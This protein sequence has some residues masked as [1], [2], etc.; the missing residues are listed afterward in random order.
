M[1]YRVATF[2]PSLPRLR[3]WRAVGVAELVAAV[4]ALAVAAGLAPHLWKHGP[5]TMRAAAVA[6]ALGGLAMGAFGLNRLARGHVLVL[7]LDIALSALVA[8]GLAAYIAAPAVAA[9]H[10]PR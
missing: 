10:V 6:W 5:V 1:E 8:A 9:T 2:R 7:R 4:V 3:L